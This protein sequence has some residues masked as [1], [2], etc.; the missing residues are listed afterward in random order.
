LANAPQNDTGP[1]R[2]KKEKEKK[3]SAPYPITPP[4]HV[5]AA[6][7]GAVSHVKRRESRGTGPMCLANGAVAKAGKSKSPTHTHRSPDCLYIHTYNM[8][9]HR[10]H[11]ID[12]TIGQ[13][14]RANEFFS[15]SFRNLLRNSQ[16]IPYLT[17][18]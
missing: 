14:K 3:L 7:G 13:K 15:L 16:M 9:R 12:K 4:V 8:R 6:V 5:R 18:I 10:A 11:P 2:K 17:S 1:W